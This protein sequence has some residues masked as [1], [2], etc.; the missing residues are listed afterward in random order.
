MSSQVL[1]NAFSAFERRRSTILS[2]RKR[3][4]TQKPYDIYDDADNLRR[5]SNGRTSHSQSRQMNVN[6][7][8]YDNPAFKQDENI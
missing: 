3:T 5:V 4:Q 2:E 7:F 6:Q 1:K 8:Q